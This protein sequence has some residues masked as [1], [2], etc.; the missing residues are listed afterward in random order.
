MARN[1]SFSMTTPQ[2]LDGSKDVTRRIGWHHLRAGDEL[3]A[4]EKGMGLKKGEKIKR[5]GTIRVVDVRKEPLDR[6]TY[7]PEYGGSECKREGFPNMVPSEFIEFFCRGH[8]GAYPK[9]EVTRIEFERL[10]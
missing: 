5:L 10:K 9:K 4:V 8:R 1:I 3:C 2:F 7:D 6:M